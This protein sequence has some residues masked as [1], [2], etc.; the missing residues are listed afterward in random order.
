MFSLI[1]YVCL[2]IVSLN[3]ALWIYLASG[4]PF[5]EA[6]QEYLSYFPAPLS[7]PITLTLACIVLLVTCIILLNIANSRF[8]S[9]EL[10]I[11]NRVLIGLAGMLLFLQVF[12][13]M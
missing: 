11:T 2:L 13:L 9:S 10:K 8:I 4:T 12:S 7:N 5:N 3:L 6:K 1:G